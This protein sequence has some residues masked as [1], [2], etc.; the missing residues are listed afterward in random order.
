MKLEEVVQVLD[1]IGCTKEEFARIM[2]Y[3]TKAT[4]QREGMREVRAASAEMLRQKAADRSAAKIAAEG[5]KQAKA[6]PF[7]PPRP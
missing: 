5:A 3:L 6:N 1:E 7:R 4:R 2:Q